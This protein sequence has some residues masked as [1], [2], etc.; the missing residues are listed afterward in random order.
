[1]ENFFEL[2]QGEYQISNSGYNPRVK[3]KRYGLFDPIVAV[4][5]N[6]IWPN[7]AIPII[8]N[9]G[10]RFRIDKLINGGPNREIIGFVNLAKNNSFPSFSVCPDYSDPIY[11]WKLNY[12][13]VPVVSHKAMPPKS[14]DGDRPIP[15]DLKPDFENNIMVNSP[16][17]QFLNL[18]FKDYLIPLNEVNVVLVDMLGRVV[19]QEVISVS[20]KEKALSTSNVPNGLYTLQIRGRFLSFKQIVV[21][22]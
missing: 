22:I 2:E 11:P 3:V 17:N 8:E 9:V 6:E 5:E 10:T 1:L 15:R 20:E 21:K 12:M 4:D 7:C 13:L 19:L 14:C 16:F 18:S